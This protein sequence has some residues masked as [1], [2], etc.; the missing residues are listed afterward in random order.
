M[1]RTGIARSFRR[2]FV[3]LDGGSYLRYL[4]VEYVVKSAD[5]ANQ[6][7]PIMCGLFPIATAKDAR[8]CSAELVTQGLVVAGSILASN[9]SLPGKVSDDSRRRE[10]AQ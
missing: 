5:D 8:F 3:L 4:V 6:A 1:N 10:N 2:S 9:A 7:A